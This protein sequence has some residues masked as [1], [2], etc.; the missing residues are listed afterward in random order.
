[1]NYRT[2]LIMS[3]YDLYHSLHGKSPVHLNV[4]NMTEHNLE[5]LEHEL[6]C[7]IRIKEDF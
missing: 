2:Q 1:M 6:Q 7:E 5:L 4:D 3:V